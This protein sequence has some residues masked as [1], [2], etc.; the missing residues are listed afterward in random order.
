MEKGLGKIGDGTSSVVYNVDE[1]IVL[2]GRHAF[3]RRA[4]DDSPKQHLHF[5]T[6]TVECY[7]IMKD[8]CIVYRVLEQHPHP[9]LAKHIDIDHDEGLY[10][11]KYQALS[12]FPIPAQ[13]TRILWYHD[14]LSALL[15]LHSLGIIHSDIRIDNIL[16]LSQHHARLS[17]FGFCCCTGESNYSSRFPGKPV[18]LNGL[19]ETKSEATDMFL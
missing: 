14:I 7:S 6:N 10:L 3:V 8:E 11:W 18:Q 15:H 9:N 5:A 4:S 13:A 19:A 2:K 12:N 17:D 16:F 1:H